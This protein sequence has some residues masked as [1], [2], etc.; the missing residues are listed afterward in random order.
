MLVELYSTDPGF[1][2]VK[3]QPGL[4]ILVAEKTKAS[5]A[6]D[7]RNG[8]GK[9]S[10]VEILHFQLGMTRL[11]DSVLLAPELKNHEFTLRLNWPSV[12]R[13]LTVSRSLAKKSKVR[14]EP[15]VV[16]LKNPRR[17]GRLRIDTRLGER[18]WTRP[19]WSSGGAR[20]CQRPN[21]DWPIYPSGESARI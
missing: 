5:S 14:L 12:S 2:R 18:D 17:I 19:I 4:N 20:P 21:V 6:T 16:E 1:K 11:T 9:S 8:S 10:V 3:F 7:S 13:D 15:N